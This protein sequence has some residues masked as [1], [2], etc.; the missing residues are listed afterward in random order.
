MAIFN[1]KFVIGVNLLQSSQ[2]T[3]ED[4]SVNVDAL[5]TTITSTLQN[6]QPKNQTANRLIS[7][8]ITATLKNLDPIV[9]ED[10]FAPTDYGRTLKKVFLCKRALI[11][12][13]DNVRVMENCEVVCDGFNSPDTRPLLVL[14]YNFSPE[15]AGRMNDLIG[16]ILVDVAADLKCL[17]GGQQRD[18]FIKQL[19]FNINRL[20]LIW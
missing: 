5:F 14:L 16:R 10:A 3:P 13:R 2:E 7:T 6:V 18:E 17:A 11:H 19:N 1:L 9:C 15:V 8:E 4:T 12:L 20:N